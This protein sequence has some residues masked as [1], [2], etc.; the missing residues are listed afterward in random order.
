MSGPGKTESNQDTLAQQQQATSQ[1]Y[2]N[3]AQQS[4][5][6]MNQLTA[7]AISYD[8]GL[9]TAA[10]SG[11]YSQLIQ[12]SGP[13]LGTNALAAKGAEAQIR[14]NIPAGAGQQ[15]ALAQI[16]IQEGTANASALNQ[17]YQGALNN[18][19]QIGAGYGAL[20]TQEAGAGISSSNSAGSTYQSVGNEQAA[21][22]A[23]NMN[24]LGSLAGA[25][26]AAA[27]GYLSK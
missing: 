8:T 12:A 24:F 14:N 23:A 20:G 2:A 11:D 4:L 15:A 26:G 19:T 7:P 3:L 18:L 9:A 16:P 22:K 17:A 1:Q 27:G 25:G 13:A 6:T 10:K 5:G 21:T